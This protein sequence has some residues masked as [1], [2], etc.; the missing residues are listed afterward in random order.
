MLRRMLK[1]RSGALI[2]EIAALIPV[3][4]VLLL[5]GSEVARYAL[6]NQ[7]LDRVSTTMGDLVAQ[8]ETLTIGDV[9]NLLAAV[10]HV[11]WPFDFQ[12]QGVVIIT[13]VSAPAGTPVVNWQVTGAGSLGATSQIGTPGHA[14]TLPAGMTV[15]IGQTVIVSEVYF[16]FVP[17]FFAE[18]APSARLY[19]RALFRPRLGSLNTL[20]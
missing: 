13:S 16:D 14:A 4:V 15:A 18:V 3:I 20:G 5:G 2:A 6:L 1:D 19:H 17:V 8:A 7:K 9:N 11:A 12:D 10:P